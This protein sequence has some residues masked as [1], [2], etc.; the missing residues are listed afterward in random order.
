MRCAGFSSRWFL[1]LWSTGSVVVVHGLSCPGACG[2][3]PDQGL[4]HCKKVKVKV[5][6]L[7]PTLC[8][9]MDCSL[10]GYSVHRI[11]QARILEWGAVPFPSPGIPTQVS[12]I[13]GRCFTI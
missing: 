7:C 10:P 8:D 13:A 11:L 4:N 5:T 12:I 9:R 6:Q 2:I 3:F 1:F